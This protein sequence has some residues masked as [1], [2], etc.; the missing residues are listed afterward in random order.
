[1]SQTTHPVTD[2]D[3]KHNDDGSGFLGFTDL[4]ADLLGD[5]GSETLADVLRQLALCNDALIA[6]EKGSLTP[7]EHATVLAL[8]RAVVAGSEILATPRQAQNT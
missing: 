3:A 7:Q 6:A 8:K 2:G 1:M 5:R 4:E